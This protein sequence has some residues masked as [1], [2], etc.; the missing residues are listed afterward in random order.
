MKNMLRYGLIL[1]LTINSLVLF[2]QA[3]CQVFKSEIAG[4]YEGKC[5]NGLANGKG[6]AVGTDRYEGQFVKGWPNGYGT[7]TWANGNVYTGDWIDGMRHGIG[8]YTMKTTHGD[9]VQNGLWQKDTYAG[10]KPRNPFVTDKTGVNRYNFQKNQT[11]LSRVLLDITVSGTRNQ[12]ISNLLM[13]ASSGSDTKIGELIGYDHVEFPVTI[14]V[15]YTSTSSFHS[16]PVN[17]RFEFEIFEPGDWTV[18]IDN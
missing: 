10:P 18:N 15:T 2:S 1:L 4:T 6:I 7:Y 12:K 14:K 13:S 5:K 8:R 11:T 16:Y 3:K 17:V 9:S